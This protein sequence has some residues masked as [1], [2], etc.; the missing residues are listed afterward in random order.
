MLLLLHVLC[1]KKIRLY[2]NIIYI[3]IYIAY[4]Q[5]SQDFAR[6]PVFK[7]RT[8]CKSVGVWCAV[9]LTSLHTTHYRNKMVNINIFSLVCANSGF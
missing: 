6:F 1:S 4:S 9:F 2:I 8:G 7:F 5:V 3:Y